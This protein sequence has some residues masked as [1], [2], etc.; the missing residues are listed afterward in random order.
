MELVQEWKAAVNGLSNSQ[1]RALAKKMGCDPYWDW[2]KPRT[3]EGFYRVQ[4]GLE[5]CIA[6]AIAYAPYADI[7]W[8]ET[9]KPV[10]SDARMFAEFVRRIH[11]NAMFAYNLSPSFNWDEAGINDKKIQEFQHEL[12]SY[13]YVWQFITLAGFHVNSLGITRFSREYAK[14]HML[15]YVSLVQRKEREEKVET[16]THQKWSGAELLD[17]M[18]N[19]IMGGLSST[20]AMQSGNTESQFGQ[21]VHPGDH[22]KPTEKEFSSV[23]E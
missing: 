3:R 20:N 22:V 17:A 15:A 1:A 6:R 14:R 4:G 12:G 11:P 16:L 10:L 19:T 23:L 7:L 9:K 13:G 5:Y 21:G 8:M 2:D 18:V